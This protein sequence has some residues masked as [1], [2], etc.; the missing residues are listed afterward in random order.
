MQATVS[1]KVSIRGSRK[2]YKLRGVKNR[3]I[4]RDHGATLKL[5]VSQKG[6]RA[7][8]ARCASQ[9]GQRQAQALAARHRRQHHRQEA[10]DQAQALTLA[11][12]E[13]AAVAGQVLEALGVEQRL[14]GTPGANYYAGARLLQV[15][16]RPGPYNQR[17]NCQDF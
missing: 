15:E 3:F 1:G 4:T 8:G 12:A 9:E 5:K 17:D 11:K 13:R 14:D 10:H 7:S 6:L 2:A 16:S